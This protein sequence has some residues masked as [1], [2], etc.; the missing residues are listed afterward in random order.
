MLGGR[1]GIPGIGNDTVG[2]PLTGA[3]AVGVG[4]AIAVMASWGMW[5]GVGAAVDRGCL[6]QPLL[7]NTVWILLGLVAAVADA[8]APLTQSIN[9]YIHVGTLRGRRPADRCDCYPRGSKVT[10]LSISRAVV[11]LPMRP[12]AAVGAGREMIDSV[13]RMDWTGPREATDEIPNR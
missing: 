13:H 7:F 1:S 11:R 12:L 2:D 8:L 3:W 4:I 5:T 10:E 6:H 9:N